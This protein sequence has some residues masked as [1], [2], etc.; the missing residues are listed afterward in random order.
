M[1]IF[2]DI[3]G[4]GSDVFNVI[5]QEKNLNWQK[6]AQK[7]T[8][9]R[10][11]NATRRRVADLKAA[12]LNPV[13]AAGSA[14]Q[15]SAPI[16]TDA[17]QMG[18]VGEFDVLGALQMRQNLKA[19]Q[20]EIERT[21]A[22]TE[23]IKSETRIQELKE[24][25]DAAYQQAQLRWGDL[26]AKGKVLENQAT[27]IANKY[28]SQMYESEEELRKEKLTGNR[29]INRYLEQKELGDLTIDWAVLREADDKHRIALIEEAVKRQD[30][31][32]LKALGLSSD[33]IRG[34]FGQVVGVGSLLS[35]SI[36]K[37][38]DK[39]WLSELSKPL[40]P[41]QWSAVDMLAKKIEDLNKERR[42]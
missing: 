12:G 11:D 17:P 28:L 40:A 35:N 30:M 22:E 33:M 4:F 18:G 5:K 23:R 20:A 19:G 34:I 13:L 27:G 2:G 9:Q 21:K 42:K 26:G 29:I 39:S 25:R 14:A 3:L 16:H 1:G 41:A 38:I 8:W 10:E 36:S 24:L 6:E 7:I 32:I 31:E 37:L 15:S